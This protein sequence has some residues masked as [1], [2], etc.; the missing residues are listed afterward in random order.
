MSLIALG[1]EGP[2]GDERAQKF[3]HFAI[4][5]ER[6]DK[7]GRLNAWPVK[8]ADKRG[9]TRMWRRGDGVVLL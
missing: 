1:R 2:R 5:L 3:V 6:E 4:G 9:G 7:D 8:Q